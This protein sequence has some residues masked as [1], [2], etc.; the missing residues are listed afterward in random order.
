MTCVRIGATAVVLALALGGASPAFGQVSTGDAARVPVDHAGAPDVVR[1]PVIID[2]DVLFAVRGI[3]AYP[4]E[5]RASEI[6]ARIRELATDTSAGTPA[7]TLREEDGRTLIL[8]NGQPF[9]RVLDEDAVLEGIDRRVLAD[10]FRSRI[11]SAVAAY[12]NARQPAVLGR[13]AVLALGAT[14]AL[15][16]VAFACRWV[17]MRVHAEI[18][19]RYRQR[20]KDVAIQSFQFVRAEQLWTALLG[21]VRLVW[22]LTALALLF[23]YLRYTLGLFPWT[24][25]TA[26]RLGSIVTEPLGT[27]GLGLVSV[28]P[29]LVFLAILFLVTRWVL[30]LIRLFFGS[31]ATGTVSLH[32]FEREWADPTYKLLRLLVVAFALVVAY[33]YV[34]GSNTDAF[35]GVTL[36]AGI[37]FSLGSSSFIANMIVGYSMTYRRTFRAGDWVRIGQHLGEVLEMRMLATHLRTPKNEEVIVSNSTIL[38]AEVVNYSSLA[39]QRGLILHTTVG[40]GYETPWRQVEA[41]LIEAAA[42]TPGLLRDRSPFVNQLSLGD[43]CVTYEINAYCDTPGRMRQ[44]YTE[45]HRNILD[46]FNEYGVQIMTPVYEGDP[47]QPKV[48]T[49]EQWYTEPARRPVAPALDMAEPT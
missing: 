8:A 2:G 46:V 43:F 31:V 12:R 49:K 28:I 34:P 45:L 25:G 29:N 15:L 13:H 37:V 5:R 40:I 42:R 21:I 14:L 47:D 4:A 33:P 10:V 44:I 32:N 27:M 1:A 11:E 38:N 22:G 16:V 24:R 6:A 23:V 36:F 7:L 41:M 3:S 26:N 18:E 9:L 19:R 35:K 30:K 39:T 20:V 48:V 17:L